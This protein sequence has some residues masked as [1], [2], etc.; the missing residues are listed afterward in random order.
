MACHIYELGDTLSLHL[1][2]NF[3]EKYNSSGYPI[4]HDNVNHDYS[5]ANVWEAIRPRD[6]EVPWFKVVWFPHCIPKH[7]FHLWLVIK[8]KLKTQDMLRSWDVHVSSSTSHLC[9]LCGL[10]P[11]SHDHIFFECQFAWEVWKGICTSVGL[12]FFSAHWNVI[13]AN[14]SLIAT[15][16]K[17]ECI[18]AKLVLAATTYFV[19]QERNNRLFQQTKRSPQQLIEVIRSTVRLKLLSFKFKKKSSLDSILS[20]WKLPKSI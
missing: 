20:T 13:L 3:V 10:Q 1:Y 9:S 6:F 19:W 4:T 8:R 17:A 12:D 16:K 11:D 7:A 18:I 2:L 15:S 5:V 14:I